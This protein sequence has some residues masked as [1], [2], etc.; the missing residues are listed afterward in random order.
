MQNIKVYEDP[1][2]ESVVRVAQLTAVPVG[3]VYFSL[4]RD[5][6]ED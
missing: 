5:A 1:V 6:E 4:Q 2:V 3:T